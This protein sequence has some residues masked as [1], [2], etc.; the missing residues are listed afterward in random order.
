MKRADELLQGR[1]QAFANTLSIDDV[2]GK[3]VVVKGFREIET[4]FG[5]SVLISVELD[6]HEYEV[7]TGSAVI[8]EQLQA[9]KDEMPFI[10][11]IKRNK[12]YYTMEG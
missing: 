10:A 8:R 11:Q 7:L 2:L 9:L 6:G 4:R 3:D 5:N 12:R 1:R